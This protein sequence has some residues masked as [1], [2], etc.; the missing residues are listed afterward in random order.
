[1]LRIRTATEAD[2]DTIVAY[3]LCLARESEGRSLDEPTVRAGV[4]HVLTRPECGV[5]YLAEREGRVIGQLMITCEWSDWRNGRF[6]WI[7]SVYVDRQAREGG[8]YRALHEHVSEQARKED[9]VCG[10]RLYVEHENRSARAVYEKL[11]MRLTGYR[12]YET[13]WQGSR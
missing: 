5:Y 11:G 12:L 7:Q 2:L 6:W 10:V 3:S 13:D 4:Q 1:M 8:V 9:D